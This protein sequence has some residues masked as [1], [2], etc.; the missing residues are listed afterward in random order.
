MERKILIIDNDK[1]VHQFIKSEL[2]YFSLEF[3]NDAPGG[4]GYNLFDENASVSST[5][6]IDEAYQGEDGF[7]LVQRAVENRNPYLVVFIDMGMPNGDGVKTAR[8]IRQ[9]DQTLQ[10]V[11][12][13]A[14]SD[15][16]RDE[17]IAQIG[18]QEKLIFLQKPFF[19][20]EIKSLVS[21]IFNIGFS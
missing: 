16:H 13:T 6:D 2:S 19:Q 14:E 9:T 20:S 18:N 15:L 12:I 11:M 3:D 5:F 8:E 7:H 4:W 10:I 21:N 17:I 1:E